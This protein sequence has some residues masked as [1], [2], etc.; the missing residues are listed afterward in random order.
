MMVAFHVA[1]SS[2]REA[3]YFGMLF[4]FSPN[5]PV[6]CMVGQA[7]AKPSYVRRPSD[8]LLLG[9]L[10][11][12]GFAAARPTIQGTGDV[13]ENVDRMPTYVAARS[14]EAPTAHAT[15]I[16]PGRAHD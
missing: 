8:A 11:Y 10:T 1:V 3:T 7:A 2:E 6:P 13:G 14:P 5:S 4:I 9:R 12:E 16:H 15:I